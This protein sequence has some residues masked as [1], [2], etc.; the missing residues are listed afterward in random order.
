[1]PANPLSDKQI[2]RAETAKQE[3]AANSFGTAAPA[4]SAAPGNSAARGFQSSAAARRQAESLTLRQQFVQTVAPAGGIGGFAQSSP[5][6][7]NSFDFEQTGSA[8]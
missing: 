3:V 2:S 4:S 8:I 7:L 5:A 1:A 6:I